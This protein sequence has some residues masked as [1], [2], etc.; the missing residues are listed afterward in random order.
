MI[1]FA[2]L[3]ELRDWLLKPVLDKL[4]HMEA[5]MAMTQVDLDAALKSLG[6]I[7]TSEDSLIQNII[8]AVNALIAKVNS[9]ATPADLTTEVTG[10]QAMIADAT[11][12]S[13]KLTASVAAA[14]GVTG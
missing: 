2:A 6:D 1:I 8:D 3:K 14:K 7:I 13:A 4:T 11:D 5:K 9:G 10:L 12:K